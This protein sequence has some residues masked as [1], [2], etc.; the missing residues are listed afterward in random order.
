MTT[1]GLVLAAGTSRRLGRSKQLL[2]GGIPLLAWP[3]RTLRELGVAPLV[4]VL[5]FN[6]EMIAGELD[7]TGVQVTVNGDYAIGM[8]TS[9]HAGLAALPASVD[10]TLIL[11]GDQ[12]FVSVEHLRALIA[13][14][15]QAPE[16]IIATNFQHFIGVP[17]L[18]PRAM[19]VHALDI[20]GDQGV[21]AL[22]RRFPSEV[23]AMPAEI[24]Q[25]ALDV[26]TEE[27]YLL[28]QAYLQGTDSPST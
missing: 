9:L 7:L 15:E 12:P 26:D 22:I 2:P 1:A 3:L 4:L 11:T 24:P 5:G 21:R 8:S 10:S 6:A 23:C 25:M 28:A 20:S 18:L 13:A 16:K 27:Q 14:A 17:V 19:W